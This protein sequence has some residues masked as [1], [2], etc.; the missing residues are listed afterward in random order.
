VAPQAAEPLTPSARAV[1]VKAK[2]LAL[3]FAAAGIT[4]PSPPPHADALDRWLEDG[5][6]GT[7]RYM[8]RQAAKRRSP[9]AIMDGARSVVVVI[10]NYANPDPPL[11]PRAGKVAKYARGADYH[12]A[13]A[14]ALDT[15]CRYVD[16]ISGPGTRS[17]PFID[18]GPVPE[19]ELAQR[20][21][22]GWIAK[23][24][25]L[26]TP[27]L[28]SFTFIASVF[29][30]AELAPDAPF[31][32]DRCGSCTRCLDACPTE[33]FPTDRVLD[34]RRCISY[35]TIEFRGD[36]TRETGSR[37]GTWV[38]GCDV[39]QDVCP[40]NEKFARRQTGSLLPLEPSRAW[41]PFDAFAALDETGFAAQYGWTPLERPGL[42]GMRRNSTIAERNAGEGAGDGSVQV[43]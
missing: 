26:I 34:A 29:T 42:R 17:R 43:P 14:P 3:G 12:R 32:A 1:A 35:L 2:A 10:Y 9:Q 40:W 5:L 39:C 31:T 7:M 36:I 11:R 33:A 23:N 13:L 19:R 24:T 28:G 21:G 4:D 15:L 20:A 22:L 6:A 41:I 25:M 37:M 30:T 38:F 8:Q 27:G 18:A 16:T